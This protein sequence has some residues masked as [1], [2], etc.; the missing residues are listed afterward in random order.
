MMAPPSGAASYKK[1]DGTLTLSQDEQ[2]LTWNPAA[3]GPAVLNIAVSTITSK[4]S[5]VSVLSPL[6]GGGGPF[7]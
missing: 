2:T 1:K 5:A 3:A 4:H 6:V 7:C